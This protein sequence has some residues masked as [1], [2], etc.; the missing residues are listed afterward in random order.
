[1]KISE[2]PLA[3]EDGLTSTVMKNLREADQQLFL[4]WQ[5]D[6]AKLAAVQQLLADFDV[7]QATKGATVQFMMPLSALPV[8]VRW[9]RQI[10]ADQ[11]LTASL[12][13]ITAAH[14]QLWRAGRFCF[15]VTAKPLIYAILNITPDS[16]YDGGRYFATDQWQQQVDQLVVEG[17]D[18][19]EVGGQ[20]TRP[21]GFA[22]ISPEEEICRVVPA[23]KFIRQHYPQVAIAVDTYKLPVMEAVLDAGADIINDV[24][25]F[26][27]PDKRQ[28][29]AQ[30]LAGLVTMH[31]SRQHEYQNLTAGMHHFFERNLAELTSAG[32]DRERIVIDQGIGYSKVADGNQDCAMMRNINQ[33]NDLHRPLLVAVSRKGFGKKLLGLAKKDRLPV[34]LVAETYM[35]LHGGRILRVHDVEE[36]RQLLVMLAAIEKGYWNYQLNDERQDGKAN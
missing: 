6:P 33:F 3:A 24:Q 36:T 19:I 29:M 16:F 18:I 15:D 28:L 7:P 31:S 4:S 21:G 12:T 26:N 2:I 8:L 9:S 5:A 25:A 11:E 10:F 17:A 22:E 1:M 27:S 13:T 30:S 34:T 14:R 20:T 35:S 23:V 32:I